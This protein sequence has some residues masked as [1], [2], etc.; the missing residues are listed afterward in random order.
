MAKNIVGHTTENVALLPKWAQQKIK[1][2]TSDVD[3]LQELLA[4][5]PPDKTN[6]SIVDHMGER[7]L[8]LD[9]RIQFR[10]GGHTIVVSVC[11][12]RDSFEVRS[13]TGYLTVL[14]A[15]SNVVYVRSDLR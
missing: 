1:S 8:P 2:L 14:P 4:Q 13:N 15:A 6:V 11:K 7:G 12:E 9:S 10:L 3:R 5:M